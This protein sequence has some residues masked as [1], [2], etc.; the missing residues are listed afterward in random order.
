[1]GRGRGAERRRGGEGKSE[2]WGE[3]SVERREWRGGGGER[4]RGGVEGKRGDEGIE[5]KML[6]LRQM[7]R[8]PP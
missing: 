2:G 6:T 5:A 8:G 3:R 7:G 1:M 4:R